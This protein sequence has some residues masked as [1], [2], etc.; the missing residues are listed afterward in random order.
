MLTEAELVPLGR[1]LAEWL[2]DRQFGQVQ[3]RDV[4]SHVIVDVDGY[5]AIDLV[6]RVE[7]PVEDTWPFED[8]A[9]MR[10]AIRHE[11][12]Q[13][14]GSRDPLVLQATENSTMVDS[15]LVYL[16]LRPMSDDQPDDE[17]LADL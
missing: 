9:A 17:P 13:R 5:V 7:D 4:A 12:E 3:V 1:E 8:V 6:A 16:S 14:A 11:A 2:V 15:P 10:Q